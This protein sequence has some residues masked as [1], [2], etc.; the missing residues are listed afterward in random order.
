MKESCT[1]NMIWR[2]VKQRMAGVKLHLFLFHLKFVKMNFFFTISALKQ[3][4]SGKRIFV[5]H[6]YSRRLLK[7]TLSPEF[8]NLSVWPFYGWFTPSQIFIFLNLVL[9]NFILVSKSNSSH[10]KLFIFTRIWCVL[11]LHSNLGQYQIHIVV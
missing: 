2:Q 1:G 4:N 3:T 9:H 6:K 5:E 11:N 10:S 8:L 7:R